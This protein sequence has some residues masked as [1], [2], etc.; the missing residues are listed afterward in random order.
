MRLRGARVKSSYRTNPFFG[1]GGGEGN[2]VYFLD[3]GM[4]RYKPI[5]FKLSF[6]CSSSET[7]G[8][9]SNTPVF[10]NCPW[11]SQT[12]HLEFNY[13]TVYYDEQMN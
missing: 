5:K 13:V 9:F 2:H 7:Q 8:Q 10:E 3:V 1:G 11:V 4:N 6:Y 12:K